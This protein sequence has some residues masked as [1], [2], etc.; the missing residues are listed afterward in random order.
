M[1]VKCGERRENTDVDSRK[2][3]MKN[4]RETDTHVCCIYAVFPI[5][6]QVADISGGHGVF[7]E[8]SVQSNDRDGK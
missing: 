8:E 3:Q 7:T 2:W 5:K 4:G 6:S 1:G